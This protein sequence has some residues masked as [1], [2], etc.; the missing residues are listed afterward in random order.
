MQQCGVLVLNS[1]LRKFIVVQQKESGKWGLPKGHVP[2]SENEWYGALRELYEETGLCLW[3]QPY[4]YMGRLRLKGRLFFVVHLYVDG[5]VFRP[6]DKKE[7]QK[8][9]WTSLAGLETFLRGN[10]C[11]MTLHGL[12]EHVCKMG[13]PAA[14]FQ[15]KPPAIVVP[16]LPPVVYYGGVFM[17]T[18]YGLAYVY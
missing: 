8:V 10:P 6:V 2:R 12:Y 9:K 7:I 3:A 1:S 14:V 16:Q 5:G 17:E 13:D 15:V 4:R 11:N 18:A